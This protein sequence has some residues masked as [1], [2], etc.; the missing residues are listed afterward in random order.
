MIYYP[1]K[2]AFR[3]NLNKLGPQCRGQTSR[4]EQIFILDIN[5]KGGYLRE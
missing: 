5:F 1:Y 4:A 2:G 3:R